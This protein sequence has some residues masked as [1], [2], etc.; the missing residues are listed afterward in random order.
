MVLLLHFINERQNLLLLV[1]RKGLDFFEDCFVPSLLTSFLPA[2]SKALAE[3]KTTCSQLLPQGS[4]SASVGI[5]GIVNL[6]LGDR[7]RESDYP[8]F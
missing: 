3:W 6:F 1:V 5:E 8:P 7:W 4:S 2:A